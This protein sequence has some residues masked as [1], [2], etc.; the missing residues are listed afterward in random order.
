MTWLE[1]AYDERDGMLVYIGNS[2]AFRKCR[3]DPRFIGVM[4]KVGVSLSH[5]AT[6]H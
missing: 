2:G 4:R 6:A 5:S 3:S 1:K